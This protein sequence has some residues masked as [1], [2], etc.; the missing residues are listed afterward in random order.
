[1]LTAVNGDGEV[2][3]W[4]WCNRESTAAYEALLAPIPSPLVVVCDGG[5]GLRTALKNMWPDTR[6]QRCLVHVQR[7][8]RTNTTLNPRSDAGKGMRKL[9]LDLTKI[10]TVDQ[11]IDWQKGLEA[12]YRLYG[13]LIHL[14]TFANTEGAQ[15]P[16]WAKPGRPW[17]WTHERLRKSW[18]LLNRLNKEKVL[19]TYLE[20]EFA[21]L[22]ISS[23]TNRL[24][25]GV[26][27]GRYSKLFLASR[28][29]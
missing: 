14:K 12:W 26:N 20:P 5:Q 18:F 6:V 2:V 24:E 15:R 11:A 28:S 7:N 16:I 13:H 25:G 22:G 10:K 3:N 1:V 29:G 9:S 23:T 8:I 19:F 27:S 17:W 4:Q 21:E